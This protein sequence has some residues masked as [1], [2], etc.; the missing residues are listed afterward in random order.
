M[1]TLDLSLSL[2]SLGTQGWGCCRSIWPVFRFWTCV[3]PLSLMLVCWLSAVR[4]H[5]RQI[6]CN[7]V[8]SKNTLWQQIKNMTQAWVEMMFTVADCKCL[9]VSAM[10][11]LCSLNMNSTKLTA[12]TY[13][14][15]K[16]TTRQ[17]Q[18]GCSNQNRLWISN[19]APSN[20]SRY[21]DC[22]ILHC[23]NEITQWAWFIKQLYDLD[24]DMEHFDESVISEQLPSAPKRAMC[25]LVLVTETRENWFH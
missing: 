15:L 1:F 9:P 20:Y 8:V 10:K 11:S 19:V 22:W 16:V 6:N 25:I 5:T 3:R 24:S 23:F 12:D 7:A 13:E 18:I 21:K 2:F 4:K 17:L 14:D